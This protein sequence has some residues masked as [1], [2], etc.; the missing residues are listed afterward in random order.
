MAVADHI[1]DLHPQNDFMLSYGGEVQVKAEILTLSGTVIPNTAA[2]PAIVTWESSD[3]DVVSV[4]EYGV[5]TGT[6]FGSAVIT[7]TSS[8]QGESHSRSL[9]VTTDFGDMAAIFLTPERMVLEIGASN[10]LKVSA[11]DWYGT[12]MALD[13]CVV[14]LEYDSSR[15]Q[16]TY[17]SDVGAESIRL[18]GLRS[19]RTFLTL[20]CNGYKS[21][22]TLIEVKSAIVLP[23][24]S[25]SSPGRFGIHPDIVVRGNEV[26][27]SS[28]DS[29]NQK[30][31]YSRFRGS[32]ESEVIDSDVLSFAPKTQIVLDP[33]NDHQ[34]IICGIVDFTTLT[35]WLRQEVAGFGIWDRVTVGSIGTSN[36]PLGTTDRLDI[37]MDISPD[38]ILSIATTYASGKILYLRAAES[39]SDD[40]TSWELGTL[41]H[42]SPL[43]AASDAVAV[44]L[45]FSGGRPRI[46]WQ[47][48]HAVFGAIIAR[49]C[50]GQIG[51]LESILQVDEVNAS[52]PS[53]V[54]LAVGLHDWSTV[55]YRKNGT[56]TFAFLYSG[57]WY[58]DVVESVSA[59]EDI[60]LDLDPFG[61]PR[62][63]YYDQVGETVRY[64]YQQPFTRL[65]SPSD[66]WQ[67]ESPAGRLGVGLSQ[68]LFV[69]E[70]GRA[71]IIYY[72]TQLG[73][74]RFYVE[75]DH[76]I[77]APIQPLAGTPGLTVSEL[78]GTLTTE[79]GG[80]QTFLVK[81]DSTPSGVVQIPI[82]STDPSE[83]TVNPTLLEFDALNWNV[84][85]LVTV[86]G[87]NDADLD[88]LGIYRIEI[89]PTTSQDAEY[90]G[91]EAAM[92]FENLDDDAGLLAEVS[93]GNNFG[94]SVAL[95]GGTALIGGPGE[96][97]YYPSNAAYIFTASSSGTWTQQ[98]DFFSA[99]DAFGASVAL[100]GDTAAI[101][102]PYD[103]DFDGPRS[104]SVD[105]WRRC[106]GTWTQEA[107]LF[108]SRG[109]APG[110]FRYADFGSAVA[111]DR[112][113][114]LIGAPGWRTDNSGSG[115]AYIFT[116]LGRTWTQQARLTAA[117]GTPRANFGVSVA[118]DGD[119]AL[120]G[121]PYDDDQGVNSGAVYV[122]TRSDGAWTQQAKLTAADGALGD[123]FG[124]SVAL[125]GN[126]AVISAYFDDD[127]G[128]SSGSVYVFTRSN[129]TWT[130]Q[131]K[132][133]AADG[134][135]GAYFGGSVALD[136]DTALIL[137]GYDDDQ[138]ARSGAVYVFTR[139]DGTWTQQAKLTAADGAA[140]YGPVA[141]DGD[142]ALIGASG[143][144]RAYF[145]S[146]A[147]TGALSAYTVT[148]SASAGG[149]IS[150]STAQTVSHGATR[151]FTVTPNSGF[152]ASVGGTCGGTLVGTTYTTNAIT[153]DCTV[154][155]SFAVTSHTVTP[156]A[157]AGGSIS[158]ST[159][160][161]VSHGATRQFTVTP[162]SGYSASVGG[163]C[164]GS[165]VGTSY[166]TNA[167]TAD[168]TVTASFA[169]TS[170]TV[171]P[172]AGAGGSISPSTPQTVSH[173][174]TRQFTVTPNSGYSASVGG[175]CGGS[176]VGTSYTTNAITADC[177]V[178]ASFAL[179]S[180]TVTPSAGAGGSISPS[181]PQTVSHGATRQFTVTANSGYSAG[182]GGTCGGSLVGTT[183]TTNAITADCTVTATFESVT[184]DPTTEV[185]PNDNWS[186]ATPIALSADAA[187]ASLLRGRVDYASIGLDGDTS[188]DWYS[189]EAQAG[190]R[191]TVTAHPLAGSGLTPYL[192]LYRPNGTSLLAYDYSASG[193]GTTSRIEDVLL[194]ESGTYYIQ[195]LYASDSGA[196]GVEVLLGRGM[197]LETDAEDANGNPADGDWL[198]LY[199][200]LTATGLHAAMG[201]TLDADW[202]D[203]SEDTDYYRVNLVAGS[204]LAVTLSS[205]PGSLIG[206]LR[207]LDGGG[208][209]VASEDNASAAQT[210]VLDYADVPAEGTY[211]IE[212]SARAG[213]GY[214]AHYQ[215]AAQVG[216]IAGGESEPNNTSA[217]ATPI[218]LSA[219]AAVAS[220]LRGRVDYASIGLDGDTSADWYS[221]EAQAGDRVTVTA[222]PL[223]GSGLTPYL[224]LYR[225]NGTSL[226]AYDYSA[227]G[228]GAASRVEDVL[229]SESGTYYIQVL[230]AS[231]SGAYGVE[232]LLG[233]GMR[234]ETDA[235]NANGTD[236]GADV[237]PITDL[238]GPDSTKADFLPIA[239][240]LD[241]DWG[242]GTQDSDWFR[243]DLTAGQVLDLGVVSMD[244]RLYPGA[245]F[246]NPSGELLFDLTGANQPVL[247]ITGYSVAVSGNYLLEMTADAGAGYQAAYLLTP[248]LLQ[249]DGDGDGFP[250][251]GDNCPADANPGQEDHESDGLGDA[252]DPDD[253]N[254]GLPDAEELALGSDPRNPDTDGDG[255]RDG[256]DPAPLD[257]LDPIPP[258]VLPSRGG[259]RAIL[260]GA[261][262]T[263]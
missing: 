86:T 73:R 135:A 71:N 13:E 51:R 262:P 2:E 142:T 217:T 19:G 145:F 123:N 21:T 261:A 253:D 190:D 164:G 91:L 252:C 54:R 67:I 192:Y 149:S 5:L 79:N 187:V 136:G 169:L 170:H 156:S 96:P 6:G 70:R 62:I 232:V 130:Q 248:E 99:N 137:A 77:Y 87:Q 153:A 151:Q 158:P 198:A 167:I 32:W 124:G 236:A 42:S 105:I 16:A 239:G 37:A 93:G 50:S 230:Y 20:D 185:E 238:A 33:L 144:Q 49:A 189:F 110:D 148:P 14:D 108:A 80:S 12:P 27:V 66:A 25:P 15:I 184:P 240:T 254:D 52:V 113:T 35:C 95:D 175:T 160:Q 111:L 257:R 166:T 65:G 68:D 139:S 107:M 161:T 209:E 117:D 61:R 213:A 208:A 39:R 256:D 183:Y 173:G 118:L 64:A 41:P 246:Y 188:A 168:C 128:E 24:P 44:D 178:T 176:L 127:H 4:D 228:P 59:G 8:Y 47:A 109:G 177:T 251:A 223:A 182:V 125:D 132:V 255:I 17:E 235:E 106:G 191:V 103:D 63:G 1:L 163:T 112:D 211:L 210:V 10:T 215:I 75:P 89:G 29:E 97:V 72:D 231:D 233:R 88:G 199:D 78:S 11:I 53:G 241:G 207:L 82:S 56:I 28:Y 234:L 140:G 34:P 18:T 203:G 159:A 45:A 102:A 219:D 133:T 212:V 206:R 157:G 205:Q 194:G 220:L 76:L 247:Q 36:P 120:I 85:H 57:R 197:R 155:A 200:P 40:R 242:E 121:A 7:A 30:I 43:A 259:W 129:G 81:L 38:G 201:G 204:D 216:G 98:T 174:A 126:T 94:V 92:D 250:D 22:P 69:D 115:D 226:L 193:P 260:Q 122:F 172:S 74:P 114:V 58:T 224:Y 162:N 218:A 225:P 186:Q 141:L 179:T 258:E 222:H 46:V 146:V 214:L 263:P 154:S 84:P 171:T 244:G 195:V 202:G 48:G 131:A 119:T 152:S 181:T 116:R 243:F 143:K 31:V 138:G 180:H 23:A 134:A 101:G 196:Y 9:T 100:D 3:P 237:I 83:G 60:G 227:S 55:A 249:P 245:R 221:F 147:R 104:G 26:H 90:G 150:P 165:L 229:L